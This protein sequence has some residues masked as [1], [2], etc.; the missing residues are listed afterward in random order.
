MLVAGQPLLRVAY[1]RKGK[2]YLMFKNTFKT[3]RVSLFLL[4]LGS[5]NVL[6]GVFQLDDL[7][8]GTLAEES[9][10]YATMPLPIVLHIIGG[11]IFNI[12]GPLQFAPITRERWQTWHRWSGRL[13]MIGGLLV[14]F[15]GLW[16]NQFYPAYGSWLKYSGIA[17]SSLGL[18]A[19]LSMGLRAILDGDVPVHRAWLM[20]AVAFGLGPATQR[21]V[22]IP[23][24]LAG[25]PITDLFIDLIIWGGFSINLAVV[26]WILW[27]ERRQI[28]ATANQRVRGA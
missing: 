1:F 15:T 24:F 12:L 14:G 11:I 19:A 17:L 6:S 18:I 10:Y 2:V 25:F 27:R 8:Q 16:M 22:A 28:V 26:E 7:W 5:L 23:Y 13:V 20:R 9:L 3:W 4:L 21:V